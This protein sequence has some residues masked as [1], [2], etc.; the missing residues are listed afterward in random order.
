[1]CISSVKYSFLTSSHEV[2]P[3]SPGRGLRQGD[4][5]SPY[6]F[7]LGI[8]GLSAL[9]QR[10]QA[11]GLIHGCEKAKRGHVV[12]H[13]FFADDS[14]LFFRAKMDEVQC[15]KDCLKKYEK[16]SGLLNM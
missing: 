14:Y 3:I 6:M 9:I 13:L 12:T 2:G 7:L 10:N 5:I 4:S 15:I 16:A 11:R 1:M 8:E